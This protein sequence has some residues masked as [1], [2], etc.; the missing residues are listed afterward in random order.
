[1]HLEFPDFYRTVSKRLELLMPP[2]PSRMIQMRQRSTQL[3]QMMMYQLQHMM[4]HYLEVKL[5]MHPEFPYFYKVVSK[6]SFD[7]PS[8]QY[9]DTKETEERQAT[10]EDGDQMDISSALED[11]KE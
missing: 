8:S 1:M 10:A 2:L 9:E 6:C 3:Q 5:S 7:G 4:M 11:I